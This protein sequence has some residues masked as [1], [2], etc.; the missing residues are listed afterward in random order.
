MIKNETEFVNPKETVIFHT[1]I[2]MTTMMGEKYNVMQE[3]K[4]SK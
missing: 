3:D 4:Q 1:K 2:N